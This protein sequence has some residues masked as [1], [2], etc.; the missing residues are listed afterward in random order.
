MDRLNK[1]I[2]IVLENTNARLF[3]VKNSYVLTNPS[4]L[5]KFKEQALTHLL[6]KL[7]VLN[8]MNTLK[9]GYSITKQN[10]KVISS[11]KNIKKDDI[12]DIDLKD[13]RIKSQVLEVTNGK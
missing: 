1:E 9:R 3:A 11:V 4:I 5:Y 8:P 7:D 12:I 10:N 13:G 2:S 6:G